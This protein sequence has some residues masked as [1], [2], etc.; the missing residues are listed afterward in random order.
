MLTEEQAK[1]KWCPFTRVGEQAS[2]AAENRP[3]GSFNCIASNCMA[4]RWEAGSLV[5][6]VS[7]PG[8]CGLAGY[9]PRL[10]D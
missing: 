7:R 1:T 9:P 10:R 8:Y 4:W 6:S 5:A 2:G 3:D